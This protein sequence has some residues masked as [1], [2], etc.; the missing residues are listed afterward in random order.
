MILLSIGLLLDGSLVFRALNNAQPVFAMLKK[1]KIKNV[2]GVVRMDFVPYFHQNH[3][4]QDDFASRLSC[5]D[6]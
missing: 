1:Q 3:L 6:L 5:E 4:I 2:G